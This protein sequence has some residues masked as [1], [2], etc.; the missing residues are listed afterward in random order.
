MLLYTF[1]SWT[2]LNDLKGVDV[3]V[4][5]IQLINCLGIAVQAIVVCSY[6]LVEMFT[7]IS[8]LVT[9]MTFKGQDHTGGN[10]CQNT[11]Y[12]YDK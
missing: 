6:N 12:Y 3:A 8:R 2:S 5:Y 10:G 1:V 11:V 4:N 9:Y 7:L